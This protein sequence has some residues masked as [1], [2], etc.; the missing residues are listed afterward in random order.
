[1][2]VLVFISGM[3]NALIWCK[4]IENRSM[5]AQAIKKISNSTLLYGA[6]WHMYTLHLQ[7]SAFSHPKLQHSAL[8]NLILGVPK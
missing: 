2:C 7:S 6:I 1:M 3:S 5:D 8:Y 4:K